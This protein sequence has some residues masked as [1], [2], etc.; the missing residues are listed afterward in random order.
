MTDALA[1]ARAQAA[2]SVPVRYKLGQPGRIIYPGATVLPP[3]CDCSGFVFWC[4]N[5]ERFQWVDDTVRWLDTTAIWRDARFPRRW[6]ECIDP[7]PGCLIVY[8]DRNGKQGHVG[9]VS[10]VVDGKVAAVI[11]CSAGNYRRTG[12]AVQETGPEVFERNG[13]ITVRRKG[14]DK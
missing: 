3:E 11:H 14:E 12:S 7:V 4:L 9:I 8:P 2:L 6:F 1:L 13:A 5:M 10:A